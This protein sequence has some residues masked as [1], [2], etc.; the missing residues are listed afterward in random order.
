VPVVTGLLPKKP[1]W[2]LGN[3]RGYA[4]F[5]A[6][7]CPV[8]GVY[9]AVDGFVS[10]RW[11]SFIFAGLWLLLAVPAWASVRWYRRPP[12]GAG[13]LSTQNQPPATDHRGDTERDHR[14]S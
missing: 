11:W 3:S 7:F 1:W 5:L 6:I 8:F 14:Q 10:N 9:W 13:E 12:R 2:V 4:L